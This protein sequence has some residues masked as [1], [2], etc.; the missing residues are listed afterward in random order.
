MRRALLAGFLLSAA[1]VS[2]ADIKPG[3]VPAA[4]PR[5]TTFPPGGT[6]GTGGSSGAAVDY[7]PLTLAKLKALQALYSTSEWRIYGPSWTA[8]T[9][10]VTM[11][12][13]SGGSGTTIATW[14]LNTSTHVLEWAELDLDT[15]DMFPTLSWGLDARAQDACLSDIRYASLNETYYGG[16]WSLTDLYDCSSYPAPCNTGAGPFVAQNGAALN[17]TGKSGGS[18]TLVKTSSHYFYNDDSDMAGLKTMSVSAWLYP[19]SAGDNLQYIAGKEGQWQ[20]FL[21]ADGKVGFDLPGLCG[22]S[23]TPSGGIVNGAWHNVTLAVDS[24]GLNTASIYWDGTY[25]GNCAANGSIGA[26]GGG[27]I[28]GAH[29]VGANAATDFFDGKIDEVMIWVFALSD[30]EVTW[31]QTYFYPYK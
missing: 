22:A 25:L 2:A 30:V 14:A 26:S 16:I 24:T 13:T 7:C 11:Q 15:G 18:A 3:F 5:L 12:F 29:K 1:A 20:L 9:L 10:T 27:M 28:L 4:L 17:S 31:L 19:A 8:P 6:A 23:Y 21:S